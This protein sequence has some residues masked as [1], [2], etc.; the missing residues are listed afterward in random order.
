MQ[1]TQVTQ[2]RR[3]AFEPNTLEMIVAIPQINFVSHQLVELSPISSIEFSSIQ[4]IEV[5][6]QKLCK[7]CFTW[8]QLSHQLIF[9]SAFFFYFITAKWGDDINIWHHTYGGLE[10]GALFTIVFSE[11]SQFLDVFVTQVVW[12]NFYEKINQFRES[13]DFTKI[14]QHFSKTAIFCAFRQ[15]ACDFSEFAILLAK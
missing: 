8:N 4:K 3:K 14:Y 13:I 5:C 1:N 6:L 10:I 12:S 15:S 11:L 9:F 7:S 2:S